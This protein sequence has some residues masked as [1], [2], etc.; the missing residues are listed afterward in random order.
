MESLTP[1]D[2]SSIYTDI[3]VINEPH[4]WLK[5]DKII[6][7]IR[8]AIGQIKGFMFYITWYLTS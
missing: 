6:Q 3:R 5:V 4:S 2:L 8:P 1:K 7:L